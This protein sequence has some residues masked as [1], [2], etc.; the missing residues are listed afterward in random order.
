MRHVAFLGCLLAACGAPAA[1]ARPPTGAAALPPRPPPGRACAPRVQCD[2]PP[3]QVSP[4]PW[5]HAFEAGMVRR[6]GPPNHRGRDAF[7]VDGEAQWILAKFTY[8]LLDKDLKDEEIDVY[9]MPACAG[10]WEKLGVARTTRDKTHAAVNGVEDTGGRVFFEV[11]R[12]RALA[13]GRHRVRLVVAGDLSAV[14]LFLEVVPR[15]TRI[16]VT[17]VDG[18]LTTGENVELEALFQGTLPDVNPG[19]PEVLGAAAAKGYRPLYLSARSER[20]VTRTREFI[21][22]RGLPPGVV[23]TSLTQSGLSGL[24][25]ASMKTT[26]LMRLRASGL[27]IDL[28]FGNRPSDGEAY[29]RAEIPRRFLL[30]A[31]APGATRFERYPELLATVA[32][33]P[34]GCGGP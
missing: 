1:P 3:P 30:R 17:D 12:E 26:E 18:T 14:E 9:V 11:P 33:L 25:A 28:A 24:E 5:L 19:A 27:Q 8:G 34:D 13:V 4:R 22:A 21:A 23:V 16:F 32:A 15:G 6:Y 29:A 31:D 10:A 20:L 2:A 7:V